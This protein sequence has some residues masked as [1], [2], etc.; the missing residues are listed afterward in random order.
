MEKLTALKRF[1]NLLKVDRQE[2]LSIY[3]YALFN[4]IVALSLPLGIQAIINLISTGQLSTS[5]IMLVVLV[6]AGVAFT[7][8]MQI[9]QLT[10]AENLQQ[11]IFTRSAFEFTYRIPRMKLDKLDQV[12]VPEMVNRFFDTLSVQKGISKILMDFS[13]AS[14]QVVFG[15]ILLSFYH[16]FFILFSITLVLILFLIFHFT[17]P[18]GL[19]TSNTEST[20]KY[21]VAHWLEEL[22]RGMETFKFASSNGLIMEKTDDLVV[23]YL[24][25]RKSHFKTLLL[26]YINLVGFRV[27]IA[28]GLLIIGSLL[29]VNG[30][31]NIGQFVASE[32]IIIMVLSSVEKLLVSMETIYDVL[33]AVEKLGSVADIPLESSGNVVPDA[34]E[35]SGMPVSL[36]DLRFGFPNQQDIIKGI[37]LTIA[38][39]KSLCISGADG[40]GKSLLLRLIAGVYEDFTGALVF[41]NIPYRAW[42]KNEFRRQVGENL[43]SSVIFRG[44]LWENLT[45]GKTS[46]TRND[47][48]EVANVLGLTEFVRDLPLGY[49]TP[50]Q[51]E[52]R[53]LSGGLILKILLTRCLVGKPRLVLLENGID[54]LPREE[55][56]RVLDYVLDEKHNWTVVA[57]S[58]QMEVA[59][60]FNEVVILEA[61]Q[62]S[63]Q[64][65]P[66]KLITQF[67]NIFQA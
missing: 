65:S 39:G 2:I 22:G 16:P 41:D 57:I 32:I 34:V 49:N 62:A 46:I 42:N 35:I 43:S 44:S 31:M 7:G 45:L 20:K 21:E 36:L 29:V 33:T 63:A 28:A 64:G 60:R 48:E 19:K 24:D 1:F 52:G 58:N 61:G 5:W 17:A 54:R 6:I 50:L 9:M 66:D 10:L 56:K 14:L 37:D 26:Q 47:V 18:R 12:Y 3:V 55:R 23:D 13:T 8:I 51:P 4:G 30:Q 25:S 15:L 38:P 40:S 53:N 11:K 59:Q 67:S 27:T